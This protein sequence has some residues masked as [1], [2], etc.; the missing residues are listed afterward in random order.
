MSTTSSLRRFVFSVAV[1]ALAGCGGSP[2]QYLTPNTSRQGSAAAAHAAHPR[3]WMLPVAKNDN[4]LYVSDGFYRQTYVYT[5]PKTKPVGTLDGVAGG[6]CP[7]KDG[8]VWITNS[9]GNTIDKY[10]HGGTTPI[11]SL[12][13]PKGPKLKVGPCA[14]DAA[15]GNLAVGGFGP[16][17]EPARVLVYTAAAGE[18]K[19]YKVPLGTSSLC[20]YDN[21]GNLFVYGYGLVEH[22]MPGAISGVVELQKGTKKFRA[23][24]FPPSSPPYEPRA[25]QWDGQYLAIGGQPASLER[26]EISRFNAIDKGTVPFN[27]LHEVGSAW[28]QGG[29]VV[30][31]NFGGQGSYPPVQI[32]RYPAGGNPIRTL[33]VANDASGV[34]VSL[35]PKQRT[36]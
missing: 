19:V 36:R 1:V 7:D 33:D 13:V 6:M 18:P 5:Y 3:S 35:A 22:G 21:D 14:I 31:I 17:Y 26:Y 8:N 4:L 29:K 30:L 34:T 25:L 11:A 12:R 28:I 24:S 16:Y 27:V 20:A 10:A 32:D 2:S 9:A 23:I 15:S